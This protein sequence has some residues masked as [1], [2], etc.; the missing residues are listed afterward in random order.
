[1]AE[2]QDITASVAEVIRA[3]RERGDAALLEYARRWDRVDLPPGALRVPPEKIEAAPARG[4]FADAFRRAVERIRRF[5]EAVKPRSVALQDPEGAA[6]EMRW[7]PIG[8]AGLYVPGGKASYPSTLAMTAVPAQVAGVARIAVVSPPGP[9]GEVCPEI[10]LGAKILGLREVYRAGGAQA[11]AALAL[12]TASIAAVDKIFGPGNAY[13]TEAKRQLFGE[14][15]I[16]LLAGPSEIVVYAD[17]TA[18][19]EWVAADLIAQAE[20]DESARP[21]LIASSA[22]VAAAVRAA[23]E[24]RTAAEA[25]R[26]VI[27][28]ALAKNGRF[29]VSATLD[30]AAREINAIAPEHLSIQSSDPRALLAKVRNAGAIYL[31]G[32]SPVALG[33]YYAGPNHVLPAGGAARFASSLSVEDFMKRSSVIEAT[34]A[35]VQNRGSDV[36][37]LAAG[38]RL[39]GHASSIRARRRGIAGARAPV[40][41]ASGTRAPS[42]RAP[43]ARAGLRAERGYTLVEEEAGI[44]LNQNESPW[45]IPDDIKDRILRAM[46]DLPWN[47]YPQ[48]LPE[49]LR[50]RIARDEGFPYEGV[51]LGN[52]SNL[53]LQWIFEAFGGPGRRALVPKPS[54]SLYG[55]WGRISE[56]G[57]EEFELGEGFEYPSGAI[58]ERMEALEPSLTVLCLPNNPTGS[59]LEPDAIARFADAADRFGGL[60]V[61]D[62]AYREFSAARFDRTP[63]ARERPNVVLVRTYSKAFAA[64]GLRLGYLLTS[65]AIGN[66]LG[67][68]VPPFHLSQFAAVAGAALWGERPRFQERIRRIVAERERL[69]VAIDSLPGARTQ[70][71]E[72]N[73]FLMWVREPENVL[74]ALKAS[75]ILLRRPGDEGNLGGALRVTVGSPEENDKLIEALREV[76]QGR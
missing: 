68:I 64:A 4:E 73:F 27:R 36:E 34:A 60:V 72:A 33:D 40:D 2:P 22:A 30:G 14:V 56:T 5:H 55:M 28:A 32:T 3:V 53:I 54:F 35:F 62:E 18:D 43:K 41:R 65:A 48:R 39:P 74:A 6:L 1:M 26:E 67:K 75:E 29:L 12:G 21:I 57:I 24:R 13:V 9:D 46:R 20:H 59:D 15:G 76:L 69:R 8:S 50:R 17:E 51:Q 16:D 45:D 58:L 49:E 63:V 71:S 25:R 37:V 38:E 7:T 11:I 70:S 23:I 10:L 19:P 47:R 42:A 61:V 52:G 31:G 44:K 66:E